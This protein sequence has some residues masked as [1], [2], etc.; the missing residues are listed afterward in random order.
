MDNR[1]EG[2]T[3]EDVLG[4]LGYCVLGC[5]CKGWYEVLG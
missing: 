1:A 2:D 3:V 5:R 4:Y